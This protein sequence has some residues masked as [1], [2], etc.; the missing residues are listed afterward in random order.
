MGTLAKYLYIVRMDVDPENEPQF[1]AWY[2]DEHLPALLQVPGVLGAYRYVSVEGTPKY[3][4]I[5]ELDSP[6]IRKSDAWKQAVKR[7]PRPKGITST[8]I[9]RNLCERITS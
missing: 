1:N 5:Y 9:S 2:N 3:T 4:A 7:T 6:R 8:N